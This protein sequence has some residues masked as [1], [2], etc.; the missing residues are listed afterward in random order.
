MPRFVVSLSAILAV[1]ALITAT[2]VTLEIDNG[3]FA[4]KQAL[5]GKGGGNG[6]GNGGGGNGG[7][8][9]GGGGNNSGGNGED[10]GRKGDVASYNDAG[11]RQLLLL[12]FE[13]TVSMAQFTTKIAKRYP[14]DMVQTHEN[15]HQSVSFYSE[16]LA[17]K[18][19]KITHRWY[20]EDDLR[21][22]ATFKIRGDKW[23][24][25]STQLLPEDMPGEWKVEIVDQDGRILETRVMTY[26]PKGSL[27]ATN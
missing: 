26:A 7:G 10:K 5:A 16:L 1:T 15:P 18:G 17:M 8:G 22:E 9:N 3:L 27:I 13:P 19:Q 25:W 6:G 2:P 23:R 20:H 11:D 24:V 14:A 4:G 12:K 21:F